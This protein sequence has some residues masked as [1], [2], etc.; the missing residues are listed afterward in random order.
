MFRWSIVI[1]NHFART[2]GATH[3]RST[4]ATIR[5][6]HLGCCPLQHVQLPAQCVQNQEWRISILAASLFVDDGWVIAWGRLTHVKRN[7]ILGKFRWLHILV[8]IRRLVQWHD[9]VE[10]KDFT[11]WPPVNLLL[12]CIPRVK[13]SQ[14]DGLFLVIEIVLSLEWAPGEVRSDEADRAAEEAK[15]FMRQAGVAG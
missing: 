10:L 8:P 9:I 15:A 12:G 4:D 7:P 1:C 13:F 14:S 6:I 11:S 2:E 3:R 5:R